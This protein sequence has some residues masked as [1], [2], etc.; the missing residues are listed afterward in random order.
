MGIT[1]YFI[2][3]GYHR[4]C[5]YRQATHHYRILLG[6]V[7]LIALSSSG[8]MRLP[9]RSQRQY[10]KRYGQDRETFH[11]FFLPVEVLH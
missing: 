4:R 1:I 10:G 7:S 8:I 3:P 2:Q 9:P 11:R 5:R 6:H